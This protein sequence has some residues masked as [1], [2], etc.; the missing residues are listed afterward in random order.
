MEV[1]LLWVDNTDPTVGHSV[2]RLTGGQFQIQSVPSQ[3]LHSELGSRWDPGGTLDSQA[4]GSSTEAPA[5]FRRSTDHSETAAGKGESSPSCSPGD[6][7]L[8]KAMCH[9]PAPASTHCDHM[10]KGQTRCSPRPPSVLHNTAHVVVVALPTRSARAGRGQTGKRSPPRQT[11]T[12]T[13]THF[14]RVTPHRSSI[15]TLQV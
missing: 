6:S 3:S 14:L 2:Q 4:A 15:R 12:S 9:L 10:G 5:D 8:R 11:S 7:A 13:V 1:V